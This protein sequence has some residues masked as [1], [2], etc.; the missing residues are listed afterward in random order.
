MNRNEALR[1]R[2][3]CSVWN[4]DEPVFAESLCSKHQTVGQNV[5]A[6]KPPGSEPV[7]RSIHKA[8]RTRRF[9]PGR[10]TTIGPAQSNP[11]RSTSSAHRSDSTLAQP[12]NATQVPAFAHQ[13]PNPNSAH[14]LGHAASPATTRPVM[15]KQVRAATEF[16]PAACAV[17]TRTAASEPWEPY[18]ALRP[19]Q[20]HSAY[21]HQN[22]N[23][24]AP[25]SQYA[26][27]GPFPRKHL[28]LIGG[29]V[30]IEEGVTSNLNLP[31]PPS[32]TLP[33][34]PS[35]T[36]AGINGPPT[37]IPSSRPGSTSL[38]ES[39]SITVAQPPSWR[40][41][42]PAT[43][44]RREGP[45]IHVFQ[46]PNQTLQ[47]KENIPIHISPLKR[48]A[49][50]ADSLPKIKDA[51]IQQ[52]GLEKERQTKARNSN[53]QE[54]IDGSAPSAK[55]SSR[56]Q[57]HIPSSEQAA[58]QPRTP[59]KIQKPNT[60]VST[61]ETI[62]T[63]DKGQFEN[64]TRVHIEI[65]DSDD[66]TASN[67]PQQP[68]QPTPLA[69]ATK[70]TQDKANGPAPTVGTDSIIVVD[71]TVVDHTVLVATP[72]IA[73]ERKKDRIHIFDSDAFDAMIYRQSALRPPQGVALQA[74]AR[75]KTP[76]EK[77]SVEYQQQYLPIN[78]AIHLPIQ[79]SEEWYTKKALD[80][81]A[82]GR[83]KAWFGKVIERRRWIRA[84]EKAE[85][86]ER[87]AAKESNQRLMR[88]DPQPWS[89]NR[90]M[91]FG[92]VPHEELP[93]DVLQN[94][95]WAKAC[96]WHREN[97]AKSI[98]RERAAKNAN[99]AA[100]NQAERVMEDAKLAARKSRGP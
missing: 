67:V 44:N 28:A 49:D 20:G 27:P 43:T 11:Q 47:S 23:R 48:K 70:D 99:R 38:E 95:A 24:D 76:V 93:E 78:P 74:P 10:T 39:T 55:P 80:I 42:E 88:I 94:P 16:A 12:A 21:V 53:H 36:G 34:N 57:S 14:I 2:G 32:T 33:L 6:L 4:C 52:N 63:I 56:H 1:V 8:K 82:R 7:P 51:P 65:L 50:I 13:F 81:Q 64:H 40:K 25:A 91:D 19:D 92:D 37:A 22:R 46:K 87:N 18:F 69:A 85:E 73:E 30:D 68:Q 84:R 5:A 90:V 79:R 62:Q 31:V 66:D 59:R 60:L 75:P 97:H 96:A 41:P 86:D 45:T 26:P 61:I 72:A 9:S 35:N 15:A 83:R 100:W 89:Y 29:L 71:Q 98:F 54:A 77:P 58:D 17:T 3:G